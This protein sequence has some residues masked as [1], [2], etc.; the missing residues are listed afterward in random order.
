ML[1]TEEGS[2]SLSAHF[3]TTKHMK[4]K[5]L[6]ITKEGS[7]YEVIATG[8][9][10]DIVMA[11]TEYLVKHSAKGDRKA[12]DILFS[13]TVHYLSMGGRTFAEEYV[14]NLKEHIAIE[15][16]SIA[17]TIKDNQKQPS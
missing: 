17:I 8:N 1:K 12:L 3:I 15:K 11:L 6:T 14:S 10:D 2:S 9:P 5:I 16:K 7:D 13:V 4:K